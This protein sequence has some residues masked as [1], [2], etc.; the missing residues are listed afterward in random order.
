MLAKASREPSAT[1]Q[2][3]PLSSANGGRPLPQQAR[4][5]SL[6]SLWSTLS[7]AP[8]RPLDYFAKVKQDQLVGL[9]QSIGKP[10]QQR[11]S[12]APLVVNDYLE[13]YFAREIP[14]GTKHSPWNKDNPDVI[15]NWTR[16]GNGVWGVVAVA[17][18]PELYALGDL[19]GLWVSDGES[20]LGKIP[21]IETLCA[22]LNGPLANAFLFHH[23]RSSYN[24]AHFIQQI[25]M[26]AFTDTQLQE[27]TGLVDDYQDLRWEYMDEPTPWT[28]NLAER[29]RR[30]LF[31]ID[32]AV[33]DAYALPPDLEAELLRLFDDVPRGHLPF[34]FTGYNTEEWDAA[35][36][37]L[38]DD[39]EG[40]RIASEFDTLFRK[41][42]LHGLTEEE[43]REFERLATVRMLRREQYRNSPEAGK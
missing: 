7:D 19:N 37:E 24:D 10:M 18:A 38:A 42:N 9:R 31:K 22:V 2:S 29:G 13:S 43:E 36:A 27:I 1:K 3:E 28:G 30:A 20:E 8:Y 16:T 41:R 35:K 21:T 39:R 34:A 15:L 12:V 32:A 5:V 11:A 25:P 4:K 23:V 26:P 17:D 14:V 33:L 6:D 40:R